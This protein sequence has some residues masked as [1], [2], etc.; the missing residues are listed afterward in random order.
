MVEAAVEFTNNPSIME[1]KPFRSQPFVDHGKAAIRRCRRG[2]ETVAINHSRGPLRTISC[3]CT[4]A[5]DPIDE[6][7]TAPTE[8]ADASCVEA[9]LPKESHKGS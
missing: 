6:F 7:I 2:V 1:Q 9:G 8:R 4:A 3:E 5:T